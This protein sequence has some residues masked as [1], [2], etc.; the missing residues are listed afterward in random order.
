MPSSHN[1]EVNSCGATV[2]STIFQVVV[3]RVLPA[4]TSRLCTQTDL[5]YSRRTS[6][7]VSANSAWCPASV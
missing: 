4:M 3:F 1:I 5:K 7:L 6:V 2:R